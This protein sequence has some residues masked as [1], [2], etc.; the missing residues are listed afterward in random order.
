MTKTWNVNAMPK[1]DNLTIIAQN[2]DGDMVTQG[3]AVSTSG[4]VGLD[5]QQGLAVLAQNG[6]QGQDEATLSIEILLD[7]MQLN[8]PSVL[9]ESESASAAGACL[10]ES[11]ENINEYLLSKKM[12][13]SPVNSPVSVSL[14]AL[15]FLK[16]QLSVLGIGDYGCLLCR[17]QKLTS[18]LD[19]FSKKDPLL[20]VQTLISV[21]NTNTWFKTGDVV[22]LLHNSVLDAIGEEFVRVT[23]SRF[24]DNLDM[25]VRQM[26][27]RAAREGV[28]QKPQ[29]IICRMG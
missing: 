18:L 29:L 2:G 9:Q 15:Q 27:T 20:G 4:A 25:A 28:S 5:P 10:K 14:I 22:V 26:N 7:D 16:G 23:L 13:Q 21:R 19:S 3:I 11:V 17:E 6:E 12:Q 24:A 1:L 8:L